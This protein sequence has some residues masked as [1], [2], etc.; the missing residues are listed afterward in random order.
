MTPNER[1][2]ERLKVWH[3]ATERG[4]DL[5]A[6]DLC[7][8]CP[9]LISQLE[10]RLDS[11]RRIDGVTPF[12]GATK[13]FADSGA[14][15]PPSGDAPSDLADGAADAP[16][17]YEIL[18]ELGRGG[19]AVVYEAR[20]ASLNRLVALKMILSGARASAA[21]LLRFKSEGE[22]VARLNHPNVVQVHEVGI[23]RGCPYLALEHCDGGNLD[24]ALA[25]G[26]LDPR[27]AT[28]L[29]AT[30][31][32]AVQAAHAAGIIHRDLK[33]Q[34]VL[35]TAARVPKV[36]D[37]GLAKWIDAGAGMTVTGDIFGTPSYMAPEQAS[38]GIGGV[39]R[40]ADVYSLGAVLYACLTGLPPFRG[41]TVLDTLDQVRSHAPAPIRSLRGGVP[42]D[43]E[44]I[45]LKC[46]EKDPAKRYASAAA[47]ADDLDR[48]LA[49][50]AILARPVGKIEGAWRWCRRNPA[51]AA[52]LALVLLTSL[53]GTAVSM[54]YAASAD[55]RR[56]QAENA[57]ARA[58]REKSDADGAR[59]AAQR[60]KAEAV[61]A[62]LA[63]QAGRADA[64]A[65]RGIAVREQKRAEWAA[66]ISQMSLSQREWELGNAPAAIRILNATAQE[67]RGWEHGYLRQHFT[68]D[69]EW[70]AGNGAPVTG[71]ALRPD[72]A[73]V[74]T[75]DHTGITLWDA[76]TGKRL[77]RIA[78]AFPGGAKLAFLPDGQRLLTADGDWV[79]PG[80]GRIKV[81]NCAAAKWE[82]DLLE[83]SASIRNLHVL[84]EGDRIVAG[85][86]DGEIR[87][88]EYPSGK[89]SRRVVSRHGWTLTTAM[90]RDGRFI[91][92]GGG[93]PGVRIWDGKADEPITVCQLPRDPGAQGFEIRCLAFSPDGL[94]LAGA[95]VGLYVWDVATG[96]LI[97]GSSE[98]FPDRSYIQKVAWTDDG[99][100]IVLASENRSVT[101]ADAKSGGRRT[102]FQGHLSSVEALAVAGEAIYSACSSGALIAWKPAR[103]P[104]P[105]VLKATQSQTWYTDLAFSSDGR[106]LV[107]ASGADNLVR[108][109][110]LATGRAAALAGHTGSVESVAILKGGALIASA[111]KDRTAKLWSAENGKCVATLRGHAA[112]VMG[113][114]GAPGGEWIATACYDG[115]IR[116][117]NPDGTLRLKLVE[118]GPPAHRVRCSPDGN[119]LA[120]TRLDGT[121]NVWDTKSWKALHRMNHAGG[122]GPVVAEFAVGR[123]RLITGRGPSIRVWDLETGT[124]IRR[125]DTAPY[126]VIS[127]AALPGDMQFVTGGGIFATPGEMK[128]WN[129]ETADCAFTLRAGGREL[130]AVAVNPADGSVA[131]CSHNGEIYLWGSQ[132]PAASA[133]PPMRAPARGPRPHQVGDWDELL[134][135]Y[136]AN[137][138]RTREEREGPIIKDAII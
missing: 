114:A 12:A 2:S 80:K 32:R 137:R 126:P 48:L 36:A 98:F 19:M 4:E 120:T 115:E 133:D 86:A 53:A 15:A 56:G 40:R 67:L 44:T 125:W 132:I 70:M 82:P 119:A 110:N 13:D 69:R 79:A 14:T 89:V 136:W 66:Y 127:I 96:K 109:W 123:K 29:V 105:L 81:W 108:I 99:L 54:G 92:E 39:D 35:L 112:A 78:E 116:I 5:T 16:P 85:S 90:S 26:P 91:A 38:G 58:L 61:A 72:G 101:T 41:A 1:L 28:A 124:L 73:R 11:L 42:H 87:W 106:N 57:E 100:S 95:G 30:L 62:R 49:G 128:I 107:T 27:E 118:K 47:L 64:D 31:A 9:E 122:D 21:Q 138:S 71:L 135:A 7:A 52:L 24:Q 10:A 97:H 45:C 121:V 18:G 59:L 75:G 129:L 23:H 111:S 84:P 134:G 17:G 77:A 113:I 46:L 131:A 130:T 88:I 51:V 74:A 3:A 104:D 43:L 33:P 6:A 117:W 103:R 102:A 55:E 22:A 60:E 68:R 83:L 20:Q 76:L 37:F 63:A 25:G 94:R 34:N 93:T 65:A 8:D 50:R